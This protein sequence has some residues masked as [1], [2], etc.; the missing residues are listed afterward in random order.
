MRGNILLG[1]LCAVFLLCGCSGTVTTAGTTAGTGTITVLV[2]PGSAT[3]SPFGTETFN[4]NVTNATNSA[5]NWEVNGVG[6]GSS[7]TGTI[8]AFGVYSAPH[9]ISNSIIP[10]SALSATV[11]ISAVSQE[12]GA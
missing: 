4:A 10:A 5:V 9:L 2:T 12:N 11:T 6:G 8:S 7:M 1:L 3:L